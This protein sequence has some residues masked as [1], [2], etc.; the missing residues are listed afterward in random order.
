MKN[1]ESLAAALS[2][3]KERGYNADF[4]VE[5]ETVSLYCGELDMRLDPDEFHVDEMYRFDCNSIHDET[6]VLY[7]I[8]DPASGVKGILVDSSGADP[9]SLNFRIV[10][11]LNLAFTHHS[12]T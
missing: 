11:K 12:N 9:C 1:Y 6:A 10:Q 4:T 5:T 8:S 2:D 3:L 7:A